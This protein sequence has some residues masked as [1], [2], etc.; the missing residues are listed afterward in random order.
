MARVLLLCCTPPRLR[1]DEAR[2]FATR[3]LGRLE[4]AG[5]VRGVSLANLRSTPWRWAR[6]WDWLVEIRLDRD[7]DW[8]VLVSSREW[9]ELLGD[10]R[11]VGMRPTL[12]VAEPAEPVSTER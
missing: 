4:D 8:A 6:E 1:P 7:G 10:L 2:A 3:E 12:L 11:L 9:D 5:I